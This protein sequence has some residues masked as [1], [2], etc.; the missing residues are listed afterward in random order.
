MERAPG[1]MPP[2]I[3]VVP[4]HEAPGEDLMA[5]FG[6]PRDASP[7]LAPMDHPWLAETGFT[8]ASHSSARRVVMRIDFG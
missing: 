7:R 1:A 2:E 3:T 6:A 5:V 8:Q 4:A